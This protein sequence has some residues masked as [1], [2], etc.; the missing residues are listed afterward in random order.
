M[1]DKPSDPVKSSP[2]NDR[3]ARRFW[4][5]VLAPLALLALLAVSVAK[6][7]NQWTALANGCITL[8][9]CCS[10]VESARTIF[11]FP[12]FGE[13]QSDEDRAGLCLRLVLPAFDLRM[14][15]TACYRDIRGSTA[16]IIHR[17]T[18]MSEMRF[19]ANQRLAPT[20]TS[21]ELSFEFGART[22]IGSP[23]TGS[24]SPRIWPLPCL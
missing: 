10:R 13:A 15:R 4:T 17:L 22:K 8:V 21:M 20:Q 2:M 23:T 12:Q 16:T 14:A 3:Y 11:L 18:T 24:R 7:R 5:G 6:K 1:S 9:G 19:I